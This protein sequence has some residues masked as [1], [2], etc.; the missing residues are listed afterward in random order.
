MPTTRETAHYV[1]THEDFP[2]GEPRYW[3]GER[4]RFGMRW[5]TL[6]MAQRFE[7]FAAAAQAMRRYYRGHS[8]GWHVVQVPVTP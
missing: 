7:S 5:G 1:V 2:S 6:E 3:D 8:Q 4:H